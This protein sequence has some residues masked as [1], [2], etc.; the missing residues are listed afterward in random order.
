MARRAGGG[1]GRTNC[2]QENKS[3]SN[4]ANKIT[5]YEVRDIGK[6]GPHYFPHST[7]LCFTDDQFDFHRHH[8]IVF[9]CSDHFVAKPYL[10]RN[11]TFGQNDICT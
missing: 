6:L 2:K 1:P 11:R 7:P 8:P 3:H 5:R 4:Q 9:M 10:H